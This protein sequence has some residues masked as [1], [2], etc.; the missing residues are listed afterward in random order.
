MRC[1]LLI[2]YVARWLVWLMVPMAT[3]LSLPTALPA[4][5]SL[6]WWWVFV[7]TTNLSEA[8]LALCL[9]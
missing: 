9:V 4:T 1:V 7:N 2:M 3:A 6:L 5:G 8:F